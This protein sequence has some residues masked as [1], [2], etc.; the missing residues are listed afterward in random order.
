MPFLLWFD[1]NYIPIKYYD[2]KTD[3]EKTYRKVHN[4]LNNIP[5]GIIQ[6]IDFSL[7]DPT[8]LKTFINEYVINE[9]THPLNSIYEI[10][11]L[12][13][14]HGKNKIIDVT[15][16]NLKNIIKSVKEN[17]PANKLRINLLKYL[18]ANNNLFLANSVL[19]TAQKNN[20]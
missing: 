6:E 4:L 5:P 12:S 20:E 11:R 9:K 19:I 1:K 3:N 7:N 2:L 14:S 13:S 18:N 8:T 15:Y 17:I 16:Y 10:L